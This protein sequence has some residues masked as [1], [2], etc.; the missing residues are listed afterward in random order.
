MHPDLM[1]SLMNQRASESRAAARDARLARNVRKLR[2]VERDLATL[3]NTF[4]VPAIP[5][6]V[7][8]MFGETG[9]AST[10]RAA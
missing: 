6:Y 3:A 1:R 2:R 5:D 8:A 10:H 4:I 9:H 7:D